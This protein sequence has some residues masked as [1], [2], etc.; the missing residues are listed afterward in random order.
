MVYIYMLFVGLLHFCLF[1]SSRLY[2]FTYFISALLDELHDPWSWKVGPK[3]K[4]TSFTTREITHFLLNRHFCEFNHHFWCLNHQFGRCTPR[5]WAQ[6][7]KCR[8]SDGIAQWWCQLSQAQFSG[9]RIGAISW[10]RVIQL[11]WPMAIIKIAGIITSV[12]MGLLLLPCGKRL[13]N[14]GKSPCY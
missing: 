2:P 14:Y 4:H 1:V 9:G 11:S 7:A 8:T 5:T 10:G 13:H 3:T 12:T 6:R